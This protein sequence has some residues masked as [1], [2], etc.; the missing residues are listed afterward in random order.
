MVMLRHSDGYGAKFLSSRPFR[1]LSKRSYHIYLWHFPIIAIQEKMMAHTIM[2]N[3]FFYL[4]FFASCIVI[5][6]ISY[7]LTNKLNKLHFTPNKVLAMVLVFSLIM[8]TIPYKGIS[9]RSQEKQE[10]EEMKSTILEN[11]RIQKERI[12][13][14]KI[15]KKAQEEF[16]EKRIKDTQETEFSKSYYNALE[17]IE[18]VNKLD[19][20]LYLDPDLYT[21]YRQV[22]GVLIG[23]S[24]ASM[25]YHTLYTYMP[26]FEFDSDHSR[27]MAKALEAYTPY[28]NED[29][30]DY[31]ILSLGSN[32]AVLHE[33]IE[34]IRNVAKG[35]N[36]ILTTIVLPYKT[37]EEERNASIRSYEALHDDVYLID[38][39]AATKH[40]PELFF[41]DKIHTGERGARIMSQLIMN[42]IIEIETSH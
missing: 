13:K 40:R 26:N 19:D 25:S 36:I 35:K 39:Y 3:V 7:R 37:Q 20:S 30:G 21:K 18:W 27:H 1:L 2:S 34:K 31:I 5:S 4:I 33:D 12:E 41:D 29:N 8:F 11:E 17:H 23:D 28:M 9:D 38:W 22:K 42:K 14:E 16:Q 24:L 10:L 15:E 6:E 32:G